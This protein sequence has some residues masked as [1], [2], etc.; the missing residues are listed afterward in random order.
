MPITFIYGPMA[1]GGI[2][3]LLVRLANLL[4]GG[5]HDVR[6]LCQDGVLKDSFSNGV[7]VDLYRDW[8]Q[9]RTHFE[10][11]QTSTDKKLTKN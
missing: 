11:R 4:A 5:G 3:T 6:M 7:I 1:I 8:D 2:E 9:A 10:A